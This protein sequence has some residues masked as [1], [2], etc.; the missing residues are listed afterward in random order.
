MYKYKV[1]IV[2]VTREKG[3][4][5]YKSRPIRT[6]DFS[7]TRQAYMDILQALRDHRRQTRLLYLAKLST[8]IHGQREI[9]HNSNQI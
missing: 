8:T 6:P 4:V 7:K 3:R 5:T 1:R 2:K 9:I